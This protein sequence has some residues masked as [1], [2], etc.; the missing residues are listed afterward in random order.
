MAASYSD[1]TGWTISICGLDLV[2]EKFTFPAVKLLFKSALFLTVVFTVHAQPEPTIQ[3]HLRG[4]QPR[5]EPKQDTIVAH[6]M[7]GSV[8]PTNRIELFDGH[9]L[10]GFTF[11]S[12]NTNAPV[13]ETWWVTNNFI[14]CSGKTVG[15]FRTQE[16]YRDYKLTVEWRFVKMAPKLDNTGV[17]VHIQPPDKV[18]PCCV[19]VQG[20]HE[21][22]GDLFLMAG[23][24]SKEHRGMDV[25]TPL[26]LHGDSAEK[27]VGEWNSS[28]TMCSSDSVKAYINDRLMNEIT[29]CTVTSGF[30]GIQSEG[31]EFEIRRMFLQPLP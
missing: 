4:V 28:V 21:R 20:K 3:Y 15:Y 5:L 11:V 10:D 24:E 29:Q 13:S 16:T 31:A 26:L 19:Q 2:G 25:N 1:S 14:H 7:D 23:A 18:W 6:P 8:S 27:P 9:N 30:I 12:R 17:L 22:Q